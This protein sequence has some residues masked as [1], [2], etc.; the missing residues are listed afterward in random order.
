MISG[1]K[2]ELL[3]LIKRNGQVSVD[4]AVAATKL[5]KTT[6]REHLT[7]L[8]RDGLI[9]SFFKRSGPGRPSL[10]FKLTEKGDTLF[11]SYE[12]ALMSEFIRYLKRKDEEEL[13]TDFFTEFWEEKFRK[14]QKLIEEKNATSEFE[15]IKILAELLESEGFMPEFKNGTI[16]ECH[17]P[18]A[19]IINETTLPC[20]LELEFLGRILGKKVSRTSYMPDG[21]H[22][23]SYSVSN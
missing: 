21:S 6:I 9:K 7:H 19:Q 3:D 13:L 2:K 20:E 12:P 1:S 4:E 15:K 8:E 16:K 18:F 22:C 5:A 14:A 11:P 10:N 23:C 17:C